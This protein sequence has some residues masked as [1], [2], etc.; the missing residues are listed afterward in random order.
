MSVRLF[1]ERDLD[2]AASFAA[3]VREG[4]PTTEPFADA[5]PSLWSSARAHRELWR[6]AKSGAEM[7]GM[8]FALDRDGA[9]ELY[10]VVSPEHR[11]KGL[12]SKLLRPALEAAARDRVTLLADTRAPAVG[13]AFLAAHG[14][15]ATARVQL[16][17]RHGSELPAAPVRVRALDVRDPADEKLLIALSQAAFAG[18]PG[19]FRLT[20]NDVRR[21]AAPEAVAL[22]AELDGAAV[23]H[24]VGRRL[25]SALA[26][27]EL[28][29]LPAHRR[30]GL[31]RGLVAAAL[32]RTSARASAVWVD[33]SNTAAVALYRSLG[34]LQT[35]TRV[36]YERRPDSR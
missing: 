33:Q 17:E 35:V 25:G 5:L 4:D 23:G 1:H 29:T 21:L 14:F 12:G 28:G 13:G 11:R 31:A 34:F 3:K 24:L 10:V 2:T 20:S 22:V 18:Q 7:M 19:D 32:R 27:E 8:S 26:I 30:R 9:L 36:K 16:L 15:A 6:A